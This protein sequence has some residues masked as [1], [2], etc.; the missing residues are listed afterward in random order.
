MPVFVIFKDNYSVV[1][2]FYFFIDYLYFFRYG[3]IVHV[4]A[5]YRS[6]D[7]SNAL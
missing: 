7:H 5:V 3:D 4:L 1:L 2:H 6:L